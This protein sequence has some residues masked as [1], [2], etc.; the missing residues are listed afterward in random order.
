MIENTVPIPY[1]L[2]KAV[3]DSLT[4][5][6]HHD[7]RFRYAMLQE[8]EALAKQLAEFMKEQDKDS[9]HSHE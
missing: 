6:C 3:Y 5:I 2:V 4:Y 7:G 1:E 8:E 9:V